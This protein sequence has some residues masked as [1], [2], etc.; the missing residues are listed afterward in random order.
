[1][2]KVSSKLVFYLYKISWALDNIG[3]DRNSFQV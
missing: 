2:V 3:K 1:M